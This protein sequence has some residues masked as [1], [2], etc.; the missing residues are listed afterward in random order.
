MQ[1]FLPIIRH[2]NGKFFGFGETNAPEAMT[3]SGR[4]SNILPP[5]SPNQEMK[6]FAKAMLGAM[7]LTEG[8]LKHRH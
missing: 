8:R 3:F 2:D 4:F 7:N 5:K 1:R 6:K